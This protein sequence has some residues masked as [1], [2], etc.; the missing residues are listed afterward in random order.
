MGLEGLLAA[1]IGDVLVIASATAYALFV[2]LSKRGPLDCFARWRAWL[3][4][5][6]SI[7]ARHL[8]C[9]TCA[10]LSYGAVMW[11]L[12][13]VARPVVVVLA[14]AGFVMALHG[15]A[16]HYHAADHD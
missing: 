16:G 14:V 5:R 3:R 6:D 10:A 15:L 11:L 12:Y 8:L 4:R 7:I 1:Q 13:L 9:P 2:S